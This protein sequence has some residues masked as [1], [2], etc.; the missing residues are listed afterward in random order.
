MHREHFGLRLSPRGHRQLGGRVGLVERGAEHDGMPL[1]LHRSD[2]SAGEL[3]AE[4]LLLVGSGQ[5]HTRTSR[6]PRPAGAARAVPGDRAGRRRLES[7]PGGGAGGD[8]TQRVSGSALPL[9]RMGRRWAVGLGVLIVSGS[10]L[11]PLSQVQGA[12][13]QKQL[14]AKLLALSDMPTGWSIDRSN[15]SGDQGCLAGL[16]ETSKHETKVSASFSQGGDLPAFHEVLTTGSGSGARYNALL[17]TL[18]H[19]R[20]YTVTSNGI[21]GTVKVASM[22]FPIQG[23]HSKAY[24]LTAHVEGESSGADLVL[25][26]TGGISGEVL[27]QDLGTPAI[28]QAEALIDQAVAKAEGKAAQS[29][30]GV[31][32]MGATVSTPPT[33]EG[34]V[35]ATVYAYYPNIQ[36]SQPDVDQAPSGKSYA[37]IDAQECAG[38][39]GSDT[40][41]SPSDFTVLLSNGST[42]GDPDSL[43]GNPTV[44]P[45]SSE[46]ELGSGSQSL[47]S[48]QCDRGWVVFDIPSA[49]APTFVQFTGTTASFTQSNTV[50]KWTIPAGSL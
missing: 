44:S 49:A 47:S 21:T 2:G 41:A 7:D 11:V 28:D 8:H 17:R 33:L 45:L 12:T 43:V 3:V 9:H 25:F 1:G 50:A 32:A 26:Q 40:G 13:T 6:V 31:N 39:K 27:Y 46:S 37:A 38:A 30:H 23:I 5:V 20:Q 15:A 24:Q 48:G 22:S 35:S 34:I 29:N 42:A 19:C 14:K 36:S 4:L 16:K 18:N 10:V